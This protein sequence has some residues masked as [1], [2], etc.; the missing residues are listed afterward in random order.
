M[1]SRDFYFQCRETKVLLRLKVAFPPSPSPTHLSIATW[2]QILVV[3]PY[4]LKL[5]V[6][7]LLLRRRCC[8]LEII[9]LVHNLEEKEKGQRLSR[10]EFLE[11]LDQHWLVPIFLQ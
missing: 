8:C 10:V 2:V 7:P 9:D 1:I 11:W 4:E 3:R 5:S 6:E